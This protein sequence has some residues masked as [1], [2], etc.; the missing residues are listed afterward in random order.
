MRAFR[1]RRAL[2]VGSSTLSPPTINAGLAA[3][4]SIFVPHPMKTSFR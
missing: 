3:A 1:L 4:T 2:D